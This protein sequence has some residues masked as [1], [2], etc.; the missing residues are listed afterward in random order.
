M[1]KDNFSS[2]KYYFLSIKKRIL[3]ATVFGDGLDSIPSEA[4][5]EWKKKNPIKHQ[6]EQWIYWKFP[7]GKESYFLGVTEMN[8]FFPTEKSN[9][10]ARIGG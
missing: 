4:A 7:D 10:Q 9:I 1:V 5:F 2:F 6:S 8:E 3:V